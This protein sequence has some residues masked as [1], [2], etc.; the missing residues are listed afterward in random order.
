M[1]RLLVDIG[2]CIVVVAVAQH[3]GVVGLGIVQSHVGDAALSVAHG[4]VYRIDEAFVRRKIKFLV[5]CEHF[6]M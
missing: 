2:K 6:L 5:A 1:P 4:F 3:L